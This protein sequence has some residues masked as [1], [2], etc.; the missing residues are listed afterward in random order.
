MSDSMKKREKVHEQDGLS[1]LDKHGYEIINVI[2]FF[3]F[4]LV[5]GLKK[6]IL[7]H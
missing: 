1:A 5:V 2:S 3:V 6:L 7:S 4:V